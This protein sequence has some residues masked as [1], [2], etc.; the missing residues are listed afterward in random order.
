[1]IEITEPI[2]ID[3]YHF[4]FS[5]ADAQRSYPT[6]EIVVN[7]NIDLIYTNEH[8]EMPNNLTILGDLVLDYNENQR[9]LPNNLTVRQLMLYRNISLKSLPKSLHIGVFL[10]IN[11]C[12]QI[13]KLP[14]D[15]IIDTKSHNSICVCDHKIEKFRKLHPNLANQIY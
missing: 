13:R 12:S 9:S 14:D 1:M 4:I 7:G 6:E 11:E 10:G 3:N 2:T 15:F 8:I 5:V